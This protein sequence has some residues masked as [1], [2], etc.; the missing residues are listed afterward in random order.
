MATSNGIHKNTAERIS[1]WE[2]VSRWLPSRDADSDYW[3][4]VT[5]PQMATMFEEAGYS[6][7]QQYENLLIHYHW[8]AH[9]DGRLKW[10]CILTEHGIS[11]VY[12]WKWN[13]A[14]PSSK[15]DIRIGFEPIGE[16]SGTALDPLNQLSS[17]E[18]LHSF[19]RRMPLDLTWA[20]HF[21]S[22]FY[23]PDTRYW[24]ANES[25]LPLATTMMLGYD[26]L[27][28]G[29]T[30][31]TYFFPRPA[32][33]RLLPMERWDSALRE[34][35]SVNN[36]S[37]TTALDTLLDFLKTNPEGK[38][39]MPTGLAIDNGT[40]SPTGSPS[41][42]LK[43]YFRGPKTTFASVREIMSLGGR[44]SGLDP[45]FESLHNLLTDVTGLPTN[46]PD[47]AD[48]PI[49]HGFGTGSSPL[50]R[51]A[52]YLYYFDIS[53][54]AEQPDIKFYTPLA[55]YGQN[56]LQ[57]AHGITRWMESQG[58]GAY[59]EN[60]LRMLGKV[61]GERKLETGNGLQSYLSCL[62]KRDGGLD[63]TSYFLTERC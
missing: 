4:Q 15:P 61:A 28:D 46:Y 7:E 53:P 63:V 23:D 43:F 36:I 27:H 49:Y 11:M 10:N 30:L 21:L 3:W 47:D 40:N 41:S 56:D 32:G 33:Q 24:Q 26:F 57:S 8:T 1:V 42:R 51:A 31:K 20:N 55:H 35:L 52:Y 45:Q 18:L 2:A 34:V 25:G 38:L 6:R 58:R 22:T 62:F 60:Y 14:N 50:G 13:D 17:K 12:S 5:G 37:G 48:V 19:A 29:L 16:H 59:C 54:Q 9:A 39:L 44:I